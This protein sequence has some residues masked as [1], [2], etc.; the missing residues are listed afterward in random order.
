MKLLT[1]TGKQ[2]VE[3]LKKAGFE[4]VRQK[5][6]HVSLRQPDGRRT[7]IPVH[8]GELSVNER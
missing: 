4:E 1:L 7:V 8:A 5:G 6:S 3:I 2:I